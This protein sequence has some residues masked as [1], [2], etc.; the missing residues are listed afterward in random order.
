ML[1]NGRLDAG[2]QVLQFG[3]LVLHQLGQ[4]SR[5]DLAIVRGTRDQGGRNRRAGPFYV[6]SQITDFRHMGHRVPP[7]VSR[8]LSTR[9]TEGKRKHSDGVKN[10]AA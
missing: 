4:Q 3:H 7:A 10:V 1:V 9:L 8:T 6:M 2:R 5:Q